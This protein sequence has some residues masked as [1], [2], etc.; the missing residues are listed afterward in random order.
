[1][2]TET[3]IKSPSLKHTQVYTHCP[4]PSKP[5]RTNTHS[6]T[7]GQGRIE[8]Y[9]FIL[10]LLTFAF[11]KKS[12]SIYSEQ[13]SLLWLTWIPAISWTVCSLNSAFPFDCDYRALSTH[14]LCSIVRDLDTYTTLVVFR[15]SLPA[16]VNHY[17]QDH[18]HT[19]WK[20]SEICSHLHWVSVLAHVCVF[21][22]VVRLDWVKN[23][24]L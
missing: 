1:M 19:L 22:Y 3:G 18:N 24:W 23:V 8:F 17:T 7:S 11:L 5:G 13:P 14:T 20:H 12:G 9:L 15:L 4:Y 16:A 10:Y 6:V 2:L 21:V